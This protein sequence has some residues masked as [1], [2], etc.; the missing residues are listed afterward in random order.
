MLTRS[1]HRKRQTA[2]TFPVATLIQTVGNRPYKRTTRVIHGVLVTVLTFPTGLTLMVPP[3]AL[4]HLEQVGT[5]RLSV[6]R[7]FLP[8]YGRFL[9]WIAFEFVRYGIRITAQVMLMSRLAAASQMISEGGTACFLA[10]PLRTFRRN[11]NTRSKL[12]INSR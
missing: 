11:K 9:H 6:H 5:G 1:Q 7:K 3:Q 10:N 2:L 4:N 8:D 12:C